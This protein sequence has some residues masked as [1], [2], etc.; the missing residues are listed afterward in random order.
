[1]WKEIPNT[2]GLYYASEDGQIKSAD[3][4]CPLYLNNRKSTY[5]RKGKI[6][7]QPLNRKGY[8]CVTI[9]YRNGRQKVV[10]SHRLIALTFIPNPENKP[11]INHIDG[12]K[13][14]N[15]I[16]NLEWC[17][18]KE[19]LDH[20]FRTGLSTRSKPWLGKSGKLHPN[21]ISVQAFDDN[22]NFVAEYESIRLASK[23]TGIGDSHIS[24]CVN[25]KR[26]HAGGLVW[27]AIVTSE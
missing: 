15:K 12:N 7:K 2:D 18:P 27:K 24:Q 4:I 14:N 21:S 6:L 11:Q 1:M 3:R 13:T 17:T 9:K 26:K 23:A 22:G 20:A 10:P 16:S 25:G 5:L 8:P 19:N